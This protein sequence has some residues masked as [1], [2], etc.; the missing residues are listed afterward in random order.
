MEGALVVVDTV[1]ASVGII[2]TTG[3]RT[4][5]W[6]SVAFEANRKAGLV[7]SSREVFL[8]YADSVTSM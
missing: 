3:R 1:G 7:R 5:D 2:T 4:F 6:A 8:P